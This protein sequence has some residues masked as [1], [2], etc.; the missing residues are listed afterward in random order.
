VEM[1]FAGIS[2]GYRGIGETRAAQRVV[3][4]LNRRSEVSEKAT[5]QDLKI[6]SAKPG[7]LSVVN[8]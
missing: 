3:D 4:R 6:T 7:E 2:T 5:L 8:E 1:I